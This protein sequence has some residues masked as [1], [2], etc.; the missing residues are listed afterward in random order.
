MKSELCNWT[1]IFLTCIYAWFKSEDARVVIQVRR[2]DSHLGITL[3]Q[4]LSMSDLQ[5]AQCSIYFCNNRQFNAPKVDKVL[6][7]ILILLD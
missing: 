2:H 4:V 7:H 1:D 6:W 5:F 3:K